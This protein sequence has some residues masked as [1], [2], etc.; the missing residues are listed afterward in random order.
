MSFFLW[1]TCYSCYSLRLTYSVPRWNH[2]LSRSPGTL[3]T[4]SYWSTVYLGEIAISLG[5]LVLLLLIHIY[6]QCVSLKLS[7]LEAVWCSCYSFIFVYSVSWWNCRF[8]RSS[9]TLAT[10]SEW[11]TVCLGEI[12]ISLGRLALLQLIQNDLQCDSVKSPAL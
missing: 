8:S 4:H 7:Y 2:N 10:H 3:A 6:L 1:D 9:G 11:S 12:A 5:H